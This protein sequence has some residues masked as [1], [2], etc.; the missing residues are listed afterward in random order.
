VFKPQN[1]NLP[2]W[3]PRYIIM[4]TKAYECNYISYIITLGRILILSYNQL[5]RF[6]TE[7]LS[8]EFKMK[9]YTFF[10]FS[11]LSEVLSYFYTRNL[12]DLA[13]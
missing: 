6:I 8:Y 9:L 4:F 5:L 7:L 13:E 11:K 1:I 12:N 10:I 2:L 3:N